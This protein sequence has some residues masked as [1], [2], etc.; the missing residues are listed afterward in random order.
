MIYRVYYQVKDG[1][2]L[3]VDV[4]GSEIEPIKEKADNILMENW[5]LNTDSTNV[6]HVQILPDYDVEKQ[7]KLL[8]EFWRLKYNI[9]CSHGD[10]TIKRQEELLDFLTKH[11][12]NERYIIRLHHI[13]GSIDS[14]FL[15]EKPTQDTIDRDMRFYS[16]ESAEVIK[17]E[18]IEEKGKTK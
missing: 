6:S 1:I 14:I 12:V 11:H 10:E 15:K 7:Y 9:V 8:A 2:N 5:I 3:S 13:R 16:A 17:T 4:E 18:F